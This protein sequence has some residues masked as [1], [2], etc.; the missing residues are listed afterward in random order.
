MNAPG[1]HNLRTPPRTGQASAFRPLLD[2][3]EQGMQPAGRMVWLGL[4]EKPAKRNALLID[5]DNLPSDSDCKAVAGLDVVLS[6]HGYSTKYGTLRRLCGS[7]YQGRPRRLQVIDLD[8][9]RM[10]FLKLGG[11]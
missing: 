8:Y 11:V 10:A 2:L 9:K 1:L 3:I 6:F 5:V 4:G 7:L